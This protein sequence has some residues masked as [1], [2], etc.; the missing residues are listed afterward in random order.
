MLAFKPFGGALLKVKLSD[1]RI[2]VWLTAKGLVL[3]IDN[4]KQIIRL[5]ENVFVN[6]MGLIGVWAKDVTEVYELTSSIETNNNA[7]SILSRQYWK[8]CSG[9]SKAAINCVMAYV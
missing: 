7:S 9:P 3:S 2:G 5:C 4:Q 1:C 8:L 6:N